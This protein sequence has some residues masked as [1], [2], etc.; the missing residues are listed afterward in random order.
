[1]TNAGEAFDS[2]RFR[3]VLGHFPT[4]VAVITARADGAPVGLAIGSFTSVSLEP[5]LAGF[6]P[7]KISTS[8]PHIHSV[9]GFCANFL[10][11]DQE[12]IGRRFATSGGDKFQGVGW[13]PAPSGAPILDDV[14]AWIDCTIDRVEDTGDHWFVLGRV[15]DLGVEREGRPLVFF[16]GVYGT[17][18]V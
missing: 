11:S 1:V 4:G 12:H 2:S 6:F 13:H 18:E 14:L 5:P 9:G 7:A 3:Q 15:H 8:W 17:F 16:R 10:A